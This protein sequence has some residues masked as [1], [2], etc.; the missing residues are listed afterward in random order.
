MHKIY[1]S[2][3]LFF[4]KETCF[5]K[6]KMS[7]IKD[8]ASRFIVFSCNSSA[9]LL[10]SFECLVVASHKY[11][12]VYKYQKDTDTESKYFSSNKKICLNEKHFHIFFRKRKTYI[13]L[14]SLKRG[15]KYID[16]EFFILFFPSE[17]I[18]WFNFSVF[19]HL[20]VFSRVL[21]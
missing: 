10:Y 12:I 7:F 2:L 13:S 5:W 11:F 9:L 20:F 8:N 19:Y 6:K 17:V 1:L 15:A 4:C 16:K 21:V 3:L 18:H 14:F